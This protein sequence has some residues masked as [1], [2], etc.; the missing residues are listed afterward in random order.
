MLYIT[1]L[2][3]LKIRSTTAILSSVYYELILKK[4]L[5]QRRC[6]KRRWF[7]FDTMAGK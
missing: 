7:Y 5:H 2:I 1:V 3:I 4:S 6:A